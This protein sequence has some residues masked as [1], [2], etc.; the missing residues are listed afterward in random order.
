M[1]M[2]LYLDV[3]SRFSSHLTPYRWKSPA[4]LLGCNETRL[5]HRQPSQSASKH[6]IT[7]YLSL[8]QPWRPAHIS[9]MQSCMCHASCRGAIE[10]LRQLS[11]VGSPLTVRV[12]YANLAWVR[13]TSKSTR[14]IHWQPISAFAE[15]VEKSKLTNEWKGIPFNVAKPRC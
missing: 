11:E 7:F 14:P 4:L 9:L 1:T 10:L 2:L 6:R 8:L 12:V 3:V 13:C 15:N 5:V